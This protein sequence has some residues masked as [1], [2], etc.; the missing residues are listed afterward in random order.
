MT[1]TMCIASSNIPIA[2][3]SEACASST[4][5]PIRLY[6]NSSPFSHPMSDFIQDWIEEMGQADHHAVDAAEQRDQEV[7][8]HRPPPPAQHPVEEQWTPS[9]PPWYYLQPDTTRTGTDYHQ[10]MEQ[11]R[12]AHL[13]AAAR[14]ED[15]CHWNRQRHEDSEA[16]RRESA[17]SD[18]NDWDARIQ[19]LVAL[20]QVYSK[21]RPRAQGT[22]PSI[23]KK[24]DPPPKAKRPLPRPLIAKKADPPQARPP[25]RP[26]IAKKAHPPPKAKTLLPRPL[27][28]QNA[29]LMIGTT[30]PVHLRPEAHLPTTTPIKPAHPPRP[31]PALPSPAE[32]V[33]APTTTRH[34]LPQPAQE[35]P[36][37]KQIMIRWKPFPR[38]E[39]G[40]PIVPLPADGSM[41]QNV[42]LGGFAPQG[43]PLAAVPCDDH[44]EM[45]QQGFAVTVPAQA[46]QPPSPCAGR[47]NVESGPNVHF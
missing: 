44:P 18:P 11:A 31:P 22:Q 47:C 35:G 43:P 42:P 17:A 26:L 39:H 3:Y 41:I 5:L 27:R 24:A 1:L 38:D 33:R 34:S 10:E 29:P 12:L 45:L 23:A 46:S 15:Q 25:A 2:V 6:L 7:D 20:G 14:W 19:Y 30:G 13:E 36:Q 16:E 32:A 4:S 8:L 21:S 9:H 28:Y 40:N 37:T